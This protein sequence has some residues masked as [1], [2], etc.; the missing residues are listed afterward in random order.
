MYWY[1]MERERKRGRRTS[2]DVAHMAENISTLSSIFVLWPGIMTLYSETILTKYTLHI[3][4]IL[5]W[6][7]L[8]SRLKTGR[9]KKIWRKNEFSCA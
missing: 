7:I 5:D 3:V 8:K 6:P 4:Y 9:D 2:F 1:K